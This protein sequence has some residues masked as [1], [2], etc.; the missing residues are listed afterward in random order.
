MGPHPK[1][2]VPLGAVCKEWRQLLDDVTWKELCIK[3]AKS[4]VEDLGYCDQGAG[5]PPGG[6]RGLFK[7]LVYCPGVLFSTFEPV[8]QSDALRGRY[9]WTLC[10]GHVETELP[11]N[12]HRVSTEEARK[13]L[14]LDARF[15]ADEIF[16]ARLYFCD[17]YHR[18]ALYWET[19]REYMERPPVLPFRGIVKSFERSEI[20]RATGAAAFL[21]WKDGSQGDEEEGLGFGEG[22]TEAR[23]EAQAFQQSTSTIAGKARTELPKETQSLTAESEDEVSAAACPYCGAL[24][25]PLPSSAFSGTYA[26][27]TYDNLLADT[28]ADDPDTTQ[29]YDGRY[30]L[31]TGFVCLSGH[32]VLGAAGHPCADPVSS[33]LDPLDWFRFPAE[34]RM[35]PAEAIAF[36][37]RF[38]LSDRSFD[39]ASERPLVR[40][41]TLDE[42]ILIKRRLAK[43]KSVW[44]IIQ[45]GDYKYYRTFRSYPQSFQVGRPELS[46]VKMLDADAPTA[47]LEK[48]RAFVLKSDPSLAEWEGL[49]MDALELHD[50]ERSARLEREREINELLRKAGSKPPFPDQQSIDAYVQVRLP[51][52]ADRTSSS[53]LGSAVTGV[54]KLSHCLS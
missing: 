22:S 10:R 18:R 47:F 11:R 49:I 35:D 48:V 23:D 42:L 3:Y 25:F 46:V 50:T 44:P 16:V 17:M 38:M 45:I 43:L 13:T 19:T 51:R 26:A 4:L 41:L 31:M 40:D 29:F 52:G 39:P 9:D 21:N 27:E 32:M 15:W 14:R 30:T 54:S 6:W 1:D 20:A 12:F 53:P 33:S 28:G 34:L 8:L 5:D 36:A 37:I 7:L 2:L 24:T